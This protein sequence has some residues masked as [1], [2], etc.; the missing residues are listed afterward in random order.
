MGA[1]VVYQTAKHID[2]NKK[3][4]E[5]LIEKNTLGNE[6]LTFLNTFCHQKLCH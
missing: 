6:D 1:D 3:N 4:I 2:R 5:K